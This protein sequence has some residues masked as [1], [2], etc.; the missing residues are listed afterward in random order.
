MTRT[1]IT[2]ELFEHLNKPPETKKCVTYAL[3]QI[4]KVLEYDKESEGY[5]GLKFFCDWAMHIKLEWNGAQKILSVLD[6]RLGHYNPLVPESIDPDGKAWEI[7]SFQLFRNHL[8]AFLKKYDLPTMWA[9][10]QFVWN[11]MLMLYG[12]QLCHTPL[13]MTRKD[14]KFRYLQK[15][16]I[17]SLEPSKEI[18][19]ANPHEKH[20]GFTWECVLNDGYTFKMPYTSNL[21]EPPAGW[22]TLGLRERE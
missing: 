17:A 2:S 8:L 16:V 10:D 6:E 15:L 12:E 3:V 14:Y 19:E 5:S 21:P 4:R 20:F 18:V 11:K 1:E 13:T 7:F 22:K 9:E